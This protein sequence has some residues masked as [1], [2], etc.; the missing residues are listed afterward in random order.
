MSPVVQPKVRVFG[1]ART[2]VALV[3]HFLHRSRW[4]LAPL[5]LVLLLASLLLLATGGLGFFA[6][7]TYAIFC[8]PR[9]RHMRLVSAARAFF[10]PTGSPPRE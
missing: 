5:L 4:F 1:R 9:A 3:G 6:P 7:F 2:V 10:N 8:C